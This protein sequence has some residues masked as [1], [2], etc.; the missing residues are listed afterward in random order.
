MDIMS[1]LFLCKF[2]IWKTRYL[3]FWVRFSTCQSLA[4]YPLDRIPRFLLVPDE[5][6]VSKLDGHSKCIH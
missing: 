2:A 6:V 4:R 3:P 5:S 1:D